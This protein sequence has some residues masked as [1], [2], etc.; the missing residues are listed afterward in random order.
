MCTENESITVFEVPENKRLEQLPSN[1]G[2]QFLRVESAIYL[3]MEKLC[4]QYNGGYWDFYTL[5]NDG[6]FMAPAMGNSLTI[7]WADN[8]FEGTMTANA[9]GIVACLFAYSATAGQGSEEAAEQFHRLRDYA[10]HHNERGLI[11]KAID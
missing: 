10:L 1:F 7:E 8:Y 9:A 3:F 11:L 2:Q 6:F 5:S 4:K